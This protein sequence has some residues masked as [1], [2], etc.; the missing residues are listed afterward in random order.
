LAQTDRLFKL[1]HWLDAGRCLTP[2]LLLRE[3]EV[4]RSTLKRD[5]A[6]VRDRLNAPLVWDAQQRGWR[7]DRNQSLVGPQY[8]LPGLWF[9]AEE[10]HALL[11]MQHLLANLDTGGLLGSHIE[12]LMAR[13][14]RILGS[15]A[16]PKADVARRIRVQT[17]GARRVHVPHFQAVGSALLRRQRL[18]LDYRGRT[19]ADVT[20]REVS[21]QRLVHYRDNWYLDAWCHWR[22]A[23]RSFSVDAIARVRVLD[24]RALEIEERELDDVLGAGYGIFAGREVKWATLRFS[25]GRARW[26]AAERWHAQQHGRWDAEGRWVLS[27]PFA[28]PRELVMDILRHV[29]EVEVIGPEDLH[30]EVARRLRAG[31]DKHEALDE[32]T[33]GLPEAG[34]PAELAATKNRPREGSID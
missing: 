9:S 20:E 24:E 32:R 10:I 31:L 1:K 18:V 8:E 33:A 28:D 4:S 30:D 16:P 23:L 13:L 34:S 22:Q 12:P 27:L 19:R 5:I 21:P 14:G 26:V 2:E 6:L 17:V 7:I 11:T 15:G 29:P 3:L 25:A